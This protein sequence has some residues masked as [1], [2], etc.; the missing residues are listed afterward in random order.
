MTIKTFMTVL[1]ASLLLATLTEKPASASEAVAFESGGKTL[2]G[3]VYKP[4][5][6]GPYPTVLYNHGAS[7][8]ML[9]NQAFELIG[10]ML[11]ARGWAMFAPYR[12]G[13][14][15][16]SDAG[17]YVMDEIEA[18]RARGGEELGART[19]ARLLSTEQLQDQLAAL[20]WL[21][22]QPFARPTQIAVMGNSFGGIETVLGAEHAG[23]CAA[24]DA[25]GAAESWQGAPDLQ[26]IMLHAVEHSTVPI[27][28]FQ[29]ENDYNLAPSRT[30]YAAMKRL[31]KTAEIRIYPPYGDGP[32][33][34]HSLPYRGA[35][36]WIDDAVRF[37]NM[38]CKP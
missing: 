32:E 34:G 18:A 33:G 26:H 28:F 16:S 35:S 21:K 3:F 31:N 10:P 20:E 2:H 27:F 19:M 13:Q 36:I 24:V 38:H 15:T 1:S 23:Y 8:G 29:A 4:S 17:P 22:K 25:A 37:L 5:G 9:N 6:T 11:S 7:G 14:G 30:L 12:R